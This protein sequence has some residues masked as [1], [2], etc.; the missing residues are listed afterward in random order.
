MN[1]RSIQPTLSEAE[2]IL[3]SATPP[4][5]FQRVPVGL[6]IS[7]PLEWG[8][9]DRVAVYF[10]PGGGRLL[11][12]DDGNVVPQLDASGVLPEDG[13]WKRLLDEAGLAY[14]E[15]GCEVQDELGSLDVLPERAMAMGRT[16]LALSRLHEDAP[17]D[18][19]ADAPSD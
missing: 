18:A 19:G 7:L 8:D 15:D 3:A 11:L 2:R 5:D 6:A 10:V 4:L 13:S 9:G 12:V 17:D 16:L 14:D 1:I